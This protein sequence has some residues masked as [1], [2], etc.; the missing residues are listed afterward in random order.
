MHIH[1][2]YSTLCIHYTAHIFLC[3]LHTYNHH[4]INFSILHMI[5]EPPRNPL[6]KLAN[7]FITGWRYFP[8]KGDWFNKSIHMYTY[9]LL[10]SHPMSLMA[11]DLC[12][13]YKLKPKHKSIY[14]ILH[15]NKKN[16]TTET[17]P[18]IIY[19]FQFCIQKTLLYIQKHVKIMC[20]E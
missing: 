12:W 20:L 3:T 5:L 1:Y 14:A 15:L 8:S 17:A 19:K 11:D 13:T 6:N 4:T 9:I 10:I 2:A 16:P 18:S 7:P